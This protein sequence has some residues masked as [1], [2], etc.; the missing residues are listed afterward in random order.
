MSWTGLSHLSHVNL[1]EFAESTKDEF[2]ELVGEIEII[3]DFE[4]VPGTRRPKV[5]VQTA[6]HISG[7]I[8][9]TSE[10]HAAHCILA[11]RDRNTCHYLRNTFMIRIAGAAYYYQQSDVEDPTWQLNRKMFGVCIHPKYG[12][13]FAIRGILIF[14]G[15][16]LKR[17]RLQLI[18]KLKT[19][20]G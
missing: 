15:V 6:A 3:H 10:G 7:L 14:H 19:V 5:L 20:S 12:G 13:W 8:S 9:A 2:A 18:I 17:M 11:K 16:S 1:Q 4:M